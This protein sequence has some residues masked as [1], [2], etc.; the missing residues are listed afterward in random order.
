[1]GSREMEA[2]RR[3]LKLVDPD[4]VRVTLL[5]EA[6][7]V[8]VPCDE[9]MV[10]DEEKRWWSCMDCGYE[11]TAPEALDLV[12]RAWALLKALKKDVKKKRR[13]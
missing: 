7:F 13:G 10:W 9:T 12:G 8:C 1:M 11:L 6:T 2:V 5:D 3:R 4:H